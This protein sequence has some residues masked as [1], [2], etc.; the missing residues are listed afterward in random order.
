[1]II[2][3]RVEQD[4]A[5]R[6]AALL[7]AALF[8]GITSMTGEQ[9]G[10]A[11]EAIELV[12]FLS[13]ATPVVFGGIHASLLPKQAAA[14]PG[15]DLVVVG[16]GEAVIGEIVDWCQGKTALSAIRGICYRDGERLVRTPARDLLDIA[17]LKMPAWH[18]IKPARYTD[19]TVQAGRGCPHACSFCY[20]QRFNRGRWRARSPAA[21]VEELCL[22]YR[23]FGVRDF[24]FID[25]NFFT[26]FERVAAICRLIID[27]GLQLRWKS[28]CRADYFKRLTP[29][30]VDL[31]KQ[32]GLALLFVGGESGSP[33]VLVRINKQ[34][35]VED[36]LATARLSRQY[37]LPVSVSFMAG[38]F[39]ETDEDREMTYD[40]MDKMKEINPAM[41]FEGVNVY[42]PYP[43]TDLF[44]EARMHGLVASGDLAGWTGFV[45]NRSNLPWYTKQENR[46]LENISFLS[47]FVFWEISIRQR[48]LKTYHYPFFWFLRVCA[49]LRWHWRFFGFAF[50]WDLFRLLSRKV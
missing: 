27:H 37:E 8:V 2:D 3:Q 45:F 23:Q 9:L 44:E 35:R 24:H 47:R 48:F 30:L 31:L 38:F 33:T 25:D 42:T 39:F 20:N 1:V 17:S 14:A 43:G 50:E 29:E 26:D 21:V 34:I 40:L 32:S 10:H 7:P 6:L 19:F 5:A 18:L 16:E 46:T 11:V 22:L 15:I 49:L 41:S 4:W 12:K 36:L 13:P 28:S